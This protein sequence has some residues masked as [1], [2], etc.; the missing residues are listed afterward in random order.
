MKRR[1]FV[2]IAGFLVCVTA[3][4]QGTGSI[5]GEVTL[6]D[7]SAVPGVAV[8]ARA[9][10]LPQPRNTATSAS[11]EYRL[12]Q[13][14]PGNYTLTFSLDGMGSEVRTL[15]VRLD[16]SYVIDITM[17]PEAVT[18]TIEVISTTVI[19]LTSAE[20]KTAISEDVINQV[21]EKAPMLR[22]LLGGE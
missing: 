18:E 4:A 9:D 8:E 7:G 1:L 5:S 3:F 19:D 14:P 17:G 13:L 10:V 11:G 6:E 22:E 2:F 21:L 15:F 12:R 16:E 20:L